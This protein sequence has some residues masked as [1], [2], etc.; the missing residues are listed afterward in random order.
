MALVCAGRHPA[1][2]QEGGAETAVL[3]LFEALP[4]ALGAI[5]YPFTCFPATFKM[6]FS[7]LVPTPTDI[8]SITLDFDADDSMPSGRDHLQSEKML[9][10]CAS[11]ILK[12][13]VVWKTA[14]LLPHACVL[15]LC[16]RTCKAS[17]RAMSKVHF[18]WGV[19]ALLPRACVILL[20][21]HAGAAAG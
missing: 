21:P 9:S 4:Q 13:P 1:Q 18:L 17:V 5:H 16:T 2:V 11:R 20:E 15:G 3:V 14:A 12:A 8:M 7:P 6:P 19:A 10:K